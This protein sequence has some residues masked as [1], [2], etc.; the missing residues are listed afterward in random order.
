[1]MVRALRIGRKSATTLVVWL[2]GLLFLYPILLVILSSFKTPSDLAKSA[3]S[4]PSKWVTVNYLLVYEKAD[5]ILSL[6][7]SGIITAIGILF[8]IV[9]GSTASYAIARW[10]SPWAKRISFYFICGLI[11]PIG[12]GLVPLYQLMRELHLSGTYIGLAILYAVKNLPISVI[13]WTRFIGSI[14][15]ELEESAQIDGG[16]VAR[17]FWKIIFPLLKPVTVTVVIINII[18]IWNDFLFPLL[19]LPDPSMQTLPLSIYLFVGQ[20][21]NSWTEIFAVIILIEA[22]IIAIYVLL[23]KHIIKGMTAGAVKG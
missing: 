11:A 6:M 3:S 16:S 23:Q 8:L 13:L 7:N 2:T 10:Q 9:M 14:P 1:M 18:F 20:Y 22:P 5:Y 12:L 17:V 21:G 15:R 19:F 4:W